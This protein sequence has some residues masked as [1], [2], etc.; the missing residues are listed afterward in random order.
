[1]WAMLDAYLA[2]DPG[3]LTLPMYLHSPIFPLPLLPLRAQLVTLVTMDY[4]DK[5]ISQG[6]FHSL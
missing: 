3:A 4:S 6:I 1:M 2:L 5:S